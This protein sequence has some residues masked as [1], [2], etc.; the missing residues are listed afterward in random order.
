MTDTTNK[1]NVIP[2]R[3]ASDWQQKPP[4]ITFSHTASWHDDGRTAVINSRGLAHVSMALSGAQTVAAILM[5]AA[6]SREDDDEKL[7]LCGNVE[8]GLLAALSACLEVVEGHTLEVGAAWTTSTTGEDE[9][10]TIANAVQSINAARLRK[11]AGRG[12]A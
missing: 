11:A 3:R 12:A 1:E 10:Q 5:Q 6:V 8:Q 9:R 2:R 4:T 7:K